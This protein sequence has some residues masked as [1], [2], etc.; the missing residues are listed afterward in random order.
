MYVSISTETPGRDL[1]SKGLGRIM[2]I[3]GLGAGDVSGFKLLISLAVMY[4]LMSTLAY[5]VL[6]MKF[7]TPLGVDAPLDRFSEA[8]AVEH[9][10]VLSKEI[11]GRQVS[12]ISTAFFFLFP[13]SFV[14]S[15]WLMLIFVVCFHGLGGAL[16]VLLCCC[17]A[18][19]FF[20]SYGFF[21]FFPFLGGV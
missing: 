4:G 10:R 11:D 15:W 20:S 12:P 9:V 19:Y 1:E 3:M 8:R 7:I 14:F 21:F 16:F 2:P 13:F 18:A 17:L 6:Y 5:R